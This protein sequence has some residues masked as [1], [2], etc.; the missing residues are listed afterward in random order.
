MMKNSRVQQVYIYKGVKITLEGTREDIYSFLSIFSVGQ[1][2][3]CDD[4]DLE[5]VESE[6]GQ[7][8]KEEF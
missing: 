4:V 2:E 1:R 6:S 7:F 3:L 8:K 5:P